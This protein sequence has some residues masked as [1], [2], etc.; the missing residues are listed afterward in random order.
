[1]RHDAC[2]IANFVRC[3]LGKITKQVAIGTGCCIS[4]KLQRNV[5]NEK[6]TTDE[7][8]Q[9]LARH[10]VDFCITLDIVCSS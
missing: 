4:D 9:K 7:P 2:P 5:L 6:V 1:M 8:K 10:H 3:V